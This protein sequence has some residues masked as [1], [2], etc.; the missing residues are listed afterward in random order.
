MSCCTYIYA[1]IEVAMAAAF[2]VQSPPPT[3]DVQPETTRVRANLALPSDV[4]ERAKA[5]T[6][7]ISRASERGVREEIREAEDRQWAT[8]HVTFIKNIR[9]WAEENGAPLDEHR[10][11]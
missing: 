11:F 2:L 7:N 8:Q 3:Q 4:M 10:A 9:E 5:L 6:I 1:F